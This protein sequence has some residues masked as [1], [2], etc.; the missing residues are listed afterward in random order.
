MKNYYYVYA[1]LRED[2]SPYYIGK[3]QKTRIHQPHRVALPPTERRV[4]IKENLCESD[5]FALEEVLTKMFGLIKEGGILENLVHGGGRGYEWTDEQREVM[6]QSKLG[7]PRSEETKR[8][9]AE[10]VR[11]YRLGRK[12][13][14]A[15][16]EKM[17]QS[18]LNRKKSV[19]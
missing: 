13:S 5:A 2:L 7:K 18:A 11:N 3:G 10:G 1:Y 4:K 9:C 8:K 12:H 16:K 17:R 19:L 15:T 6:R 14:E